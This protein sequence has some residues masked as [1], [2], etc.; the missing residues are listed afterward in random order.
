MVF[1]YKR[2]AHFT[3][4]KYKVSATKVLDRL[5]TIITLLCDKNKFIIGGSKKEG[6]NF[7]TICRVWCRNFFFLKPLFS[8]VTQFIYICFHYLYTVPKSD[9]YCSIYLIFLT[10]QSVLI[11]WYT[12]SNWPQYFECDEIA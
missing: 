6:K 10:N 8:I 3:E 9:L 12:L 7:E 4:R 11:V 2:M 1:Q 5:S